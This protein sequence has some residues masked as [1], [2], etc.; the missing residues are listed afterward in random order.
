MKTRNKRKRYL[1]AVFLLLSV[2]PALGQTWQCE[3]LPS[4][5]I[6][7]KD[8]GSGARIIFVT[9]DLASDNNLYFHDRCWMFDQQLMLFNSDRTGRKEIFGY[10]AST[11]ALVRFNRPEDPAAFNPVASAKGDR[12]YVFKENKVCEWKVELVEKPDWKVFVSERKIC[13]LPPGAKPIHSLNENSDRSLI[14]IGYVLNG[15]YHI[16]VANI[17]SGKI[18]HIAALNF[19]IQHLQFSWERPDLL[20]FARS[21]GSDTAPDDPD[22]PPH[23]RIWLVNVLTKAPVP[24]FYQVPGELVTHE[25]WWVHDQIT[26]IGGYRPE[27]SHVKVIDIMTGE[28]RIIGAGA[29]LEGVT[30]RELSKVNWWHASG[31]P[32][33]R[34]VAADNWHGTIAIFDG[35]TTRKRILTS[36]HRTYGKGAHPHVGW[37][38]NSTS[39]EFTSNKLGHPDVCI[40]ELPESWLK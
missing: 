10:I 5:R 13:D 19:Q 11:G 3:I 7:E 14:S 37:D 18:S 16:D 33:G 9:T 4:E 28:I 2:V 36:G 31:S 1:L 25:C 34:W 38:L 8:E 39:V 29:W 27:E 17:K 15:L 24:L 32:D 6:V 21:Y 23:A 30:A 26:F 40:A 22:E 35:R 12:L 20:S